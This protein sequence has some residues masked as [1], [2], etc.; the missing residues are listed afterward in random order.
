LDLARVRTVNLV[1]SGIGSAVFAALFLYVTIA[2][3]DFDRRLRDFAIARVQERAG[4]ELQKLPQFQ[5]MAKGSKSLGAFSRKLERRVGQLRVGL[6]GGTDRFIADILT[7]ACKLDCEKREQARIAVR[8]IFE[9]SMAR[10]GVALDRIQDMVMGH[11][12]A[13]MDELRG[14]IKVFAASSFLALLSAFLLS[15]FYGRAARHLLPISLALTAATVL[16]VVWYV[17]GQD[18]AMT[19]IFGDYWGWAYAALLS[20]LAVLMADIAANRAQVTSAVFNLI[21]GSFTCY[22]P[23]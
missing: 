3:G 6:Q 22:A 18:W 19:I 14:D 4:S 13:V 23:C 2:P 7:A 8:G 15:L 10:Y 20:V 16:A 11:Y 21:G 12:Q 9:M 1:L 5:S 17:F